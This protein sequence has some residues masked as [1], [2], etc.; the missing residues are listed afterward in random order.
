MHIVGLQIVP[1]GLPR[2]SRCCFT[3]FV[4]RL[5]FK[6]PKGGRPSPITGAIKAHG[7]RSYKWSTGSAMN[8]WDWWPEVRASETK[9]PCHAGSFGRISKLGPPNVPAGNYIAFYDTPSMYWTPAFAPAF[10]AGAERIDSNFFQDVYFGCEKNGTIKRV[11][12]HLHQ[13]FRLSNGIIQKGKAVIKREFSDGRAFDSQVKALEAAVPLAGRK[14]KIA[15]NGKR[16][17]QQ[18]TKAWG[19]KHGP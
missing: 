13:V 11:S 2:S 18:T 1:G 4:A 6:T 12:I 7:K 15:L 16:P 9:N 17:G 14:P 3:S 10:K 19:P 5:G 8:H